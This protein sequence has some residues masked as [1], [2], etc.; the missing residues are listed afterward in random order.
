[1]KGNMC[2]RLK[3]WS[4]VIGTALLPDMDDFTICWLYEW[5]KYGK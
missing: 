2:C 1:M 3:K 5:K 4:C